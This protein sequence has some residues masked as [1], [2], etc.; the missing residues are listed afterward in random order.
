VVI[1]WTTTSQ[2]PDERGVEI[3]AHA[4][5]QC[6]FLCGDTSESPCPVTAQPNAMFIAWGSDPI[7]RKSQ[8]LHKTTTSGCGHDSLTD[9]G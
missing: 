5:V 8:F 2:S 3:P 4:A 9:A 6:L 1:L 7:P